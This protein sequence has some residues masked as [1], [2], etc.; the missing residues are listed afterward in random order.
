MNTRVAM[1][2]KFPS[3]ILNEFLNIWSWV[4]LFIYNA[5]GPWRVLIDS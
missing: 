3:S 5:N 4:Q 2:Y 1:I